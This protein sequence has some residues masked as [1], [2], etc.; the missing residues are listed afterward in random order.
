MSESQ[1]FPRHFSARL[2]Q[3]CSSRPYIIIRRLDIFR[4]TEGRSTLVPLLIV[5]TLAPV[6]LSVSHHHRA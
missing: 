3:V 4:Q 5:E 6:R 1:D 2:A